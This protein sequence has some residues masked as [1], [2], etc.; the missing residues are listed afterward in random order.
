MIGGLA[1]GHS[2]HDVTAEHTALVNSHLA[3]LNAKLGT[4][5]TSFTVNSVHTQVVAGTNYFFHLTSND[6]H[7]YSASFYEPLPHTGNPITLSWAEADHTQ[8]RC[9]Q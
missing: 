9:H 7:K 5:A 8:A 2:S 4:H 6:G 3:D 1:G